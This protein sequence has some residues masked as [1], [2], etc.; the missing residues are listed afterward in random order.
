LVTTVEPT[1]KLSNLSL[2]TMLDAGS[3]TMAVDF[4]EAIASDARLVICVNVPRSWRL[5]SKEMKELYTATEPVTNRAEAK[6][7]SVYSSISLIEAKGP[8]GI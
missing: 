3:E 5:D 8:I 6:T 4:P 1:P 2:Q 7:T